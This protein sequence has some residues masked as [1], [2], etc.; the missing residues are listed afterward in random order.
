[1]GWIVWRGTGS[2]IRINTIV[3]LDVA[4]GAM[5]SVT[6][7]YPILATRLLTEFSRLKPTPSLWVPWFAVPTHEVHDCQ[8]ELGEL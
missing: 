6:K 3:H 5:V 1:M 8:Y 2:A 4:N 7:S